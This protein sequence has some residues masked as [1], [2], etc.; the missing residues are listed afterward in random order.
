LFAKESAA[1][2]SFLCD[3]SYAGA[4]PPL[5]SLA[6]LPCSGVSFPA[7]FGERFMRTY[8]TIVV[9]DPALTEGELK[10]EIKRVEGIIA[11]QRPEGGKGITQDFWGKKEL[12]FAVGKNHYGYFVR[13]GYGLAEPTKASEITNLLRITEK[14]IR[15][16]THLTDLRQRKV[17]VNPKRVI[18]PESMDSFG[19]DLDF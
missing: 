14:V 3:R 12:P 15:F 13:F 9:F 4:A 19:A 1:I 11:A 2:S 10:N 18:T 7:L 17:K 5:P 16:Q 8:E 6:V